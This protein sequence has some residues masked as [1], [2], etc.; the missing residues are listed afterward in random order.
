MPCGLFH[1]RYRTDERV[2]QTIWVRS[3]IA[4]LGL[5]VLLL[6][7]FASGYILYVANTIFIFIV[8]AIG[9]NIL[10]GFTGQISIGHGAFVAIGAYSS[11]IITTKLNLPFWLAMPAGGLSAA[12]IG[13][14]FGIPSLRV[15][16]LYLAI[17]TLAAQFITDYTIVHWESLTNGITGMFVPSPDLF[18]FVFDSDRK[19]YYLL[20]VFAAVAVVSGRNLFRTRIGR[21]L[22]AVRDRDI[23]AELIGIS[24]FKYK[25]LAF[26]LSSFYAGIAGG[27][28]GFYTN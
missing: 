10:T 28:W 11:A 12:L 2:F 19:Y 20:L 4:G 5:F 17:A 9:L 6:P 3:W 23:A 24:L 22:I 26:A 8:G 16:G 1:T 21:A 15:K 18:G 27:L 7:F 13:M 25:L 14:V